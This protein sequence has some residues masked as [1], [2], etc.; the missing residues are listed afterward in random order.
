MATLAALGAYKGSDSESDEENLNCAKQADALA[1]M[2]ST[3][4]PASI[5]PS[6]EI[7]TAPTVITKYDVH[8]GRSVDLTK[9]EIVFNP[10]VEEMY[11]PE[12][13]PSNPLKSTQA[14]A[15]RNTLAGYAEKE[16][17]SDFAFE[18]QR[19]NFHSYGTAIDPSKPFGN[20][21]EDMQTVTSYHGID[22]KAVEQGGSVWMNVK[23]K[24][25]KR[26]KNDDAG[27]IE[28][29]KGPWA[30]YKD[31]KSM[32]DTNPAGEVREELDDILGKIR[33]RQQRS[34]RSKANDDDDDVVMEK[35]QLHIN[36]PNDYL[37]RNY[38]HPP[39][40]QGVNWKETHTVE[41]CYL[42]KKLIHTFK[43]HQKG[44]TNIQLFPGTGHL[45]LSASMDN[46]L[47]LW[48]TYGK[49]RLLRTY[50][51]HSKGVRQTDM[52][53]KG[54]N[55][56]SASYDR[57]IKYWDTETGKC[58]SKFTNRKIP[59][60]V[61]FN[62]DPDKQHI[63]LAGCNDKKV[64]AWDIRSGNIVQE[65]DRHLNP[66]NSITFIDDNK[67]F[68]TTSDD[69]SIRVWEWDIPVDF[70]YI[71][72]PG[73]HSMP[74]AVKSPDNRFVCLQS[75][76]NTISTYDCTGGKFR[77]KRKKIFKGHL[78]AGYAC[79]P[80]FSPDMS[81]LCSGDGQ[82]K[83]HI[84]DWKT[85]RLYSKFKAHDEVVICTTWLP[86]EPSKLVT[87]SWDGTIKLWD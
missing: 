30:K 49:R 74:A 71:A 72:D 64:S 14:A 50:D 18:T 23:R 57:F 37:G 17:I 69:K 68:V 40:D 8:N 42:P 24:K 2:T 25:R 39:M 41:R 1:H 48:E 32:E 44:V 5:K 85:T 11:M 86:K 10:T 27:D 12:Q 33:K 29:W 22:Q 87:C 51:G 19:R 79:V 55:F 6:M 26:V 78:V 34:N 76:D 73:M 66:I 9:G 31:E 77:P 58:I 59:Y 38:L 45:L 36:D 28:G 20:P 75:L 35:T 80:T 60:V 70:K 83:V 7:V 43:G 3:K 54:E 4:K 62:P 61:K 53:L 65:Y 47:K 15:E 13:G 67:R 52:T 16:H 56:I 46:K 63:F 84:W 21:E 81:Y 82:G